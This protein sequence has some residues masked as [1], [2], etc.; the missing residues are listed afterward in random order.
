VRHTEAWTHG[1]GL[2][3]DLLGKYTPMVS[4]SGIPRTAALVEQKEEREKVVSGREALNP[5]GRIF[6]NLTSQQLACNALF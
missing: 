1:L 2:Q 3:S 6:N 5:C 4:A